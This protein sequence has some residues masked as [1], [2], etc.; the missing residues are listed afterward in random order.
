MPKDLDSLDDLPWSEADWQVVLIA[1]QLRDQKGVF[2][3]VTRRPDGTAR[4][5]FTTALEMPAPKEVVV[6]KARKARVPRRIPHSAVEQLV[7][8]LGAVKA[9]EMRI[10][11]AAISPLTQQVQAAQMQERIKALV[12]VNELSAFGS[13]IA[14]RARVASLLSPIS[15]L[16][17]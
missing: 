15:P 1:K 7:A 14:D 11:S 17:D 16:D 3:E 5:E 6:S 10:L 4:L 2:L 9:S 12:A 13:L 8:S